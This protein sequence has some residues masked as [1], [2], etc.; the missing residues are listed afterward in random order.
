MKRLFNILPLVAL[1]FGAVA[2][3]SCTN[4]LGDDNMSPNG[5]GSSD[6]IVLNFDAPQSDVVIQTRAQNLDDQNENRVRNL[7]VFIFDADG[8]KVYSYYFDSS[9]KV[10]NVTGR[11]DN[12]WSV[13]NTDNV[14]TKRTQ[15]KIMIRTTSKADA[16][17]SIY[18]ITNLDSSFVDIS[19]DRLSQIQTEEE[20]LRTQGKMLQQTVSRS[21]YLQMSG[22]ME[23]VNIDGDG[24]I[25][26]ATDATL[27][28]YHMD[29]KVQVTLTH[30]SN[31]M[32]LSNARIQIVNLPKVS[33]VWSKY[34]PNDATSTGQ[35]EVTSKEDVF[36]SA[37]MGFDDISQSTTAGV[38]TTTCK[39]WFYMLES[40]QTPK[41]QIPMACPDSEW[42][43]YDPAKTNYNPY[44]ERA[45]QTKDATPLTPG[46]GHNQ[47]DGEGNR[48]FMYANNLSPYMLIRCNIAMEL[49]GEEAGQEL[50]GDVSYLIPLG[51][52]G[53]SAS[54][55]E[56]KVNNYNTNRNTFYHYTVT[57]NGVHNVRVEVDARGTDITDNNFQMEENQPGATGKVVVAKEEIAICDCHY[58]TKT[59][60]FHAKNVSD[61]LTW[62]VSTPFGEGGPQ[63][64]IEGNDVIPPG[65]DYEWAHFRVNKKTSSGAY[66]SDQRRAYTIE[67]YDPVTKPEGLMN[68]SQLV[69][70]MKEQ[71]KLY[72]TEDP[73]RPELWTSD[74]DNGKMVTYNDNGTVKGEED[75]P[76]GRK[77][78]VTVF[79][80]E[81]YYDYNPLNPLEEI[82]ADFWKQYVNYP[83]DRYMYILSESNLSRDE[84]S[85]STGSVVTIQQHP[86]QSIFDT[87]PANTTFKTAWGLE[88]TDEDEGKLNK[89]YTSGSGTDNRGNTDKYNGR[90]N[91]MK[92]WGLVNTTGTTYT[93]KKWSDFMNFEVRN[94][95]PQLQNTYKYLRYS[96]M[97]RN[98]DN[99]G[100]DN[101]DQNEIRWYMAAIK[102]LTGIAV[103]RS[104]LLPESRLYKRSSEDKASN[105]P[106]KWRQH[107]VSSTMLD[108]NSNQP[109]V[110]WGEE[111]T[112]ISDLSGSKQY[113]SST[114]YT[115]NTW[116][117]RCVRN[118]GTK[119]ETLA[120]GYTLSEKPDD[121][122][123]V[124]T[125]GTNHQVTCVRINPQALR[126][127]QNTELVFCDENNEQALLS[128]RF[129]IAGTVNSLPTLPGG[130]N[131]GHAFLNHNQWVEDVGSSGPVASGGTGHCPEGYRIPNMLEFTII[132]N[133]ADDL[134]DQ[135][136]ELGRA[137]IDWT[138]NGYF[139]RNYYSFGMMGEYKKN[140]E[141]GKPGW[142]AGDNT[143]TIQNNI[144][145][146]RCVR[147]ASVD[148]LRAE[149]LL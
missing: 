66:Y 125:D 38:T 96:C 120:S 77:I 1:L 117:V 33:Y 145:K 116:S 121:Y 118:L 112:S 111:I 124:H 127:Q 134:N 126:A 30:G 37:E 32:S 143:I 7:Y 144:S 137:D 135:L 91:T 16:D 14:G 106:N 65:L 62:S 103:G 42:E 49:T 34:A 95:L 24:N 55:V 78:C 87:N 84:E 63:I 40:R 57:V 56:A 86:I 138:E 6:C 27:H 128:K 12:C 31:V 100:D 132:F 148:E 11:N 119:N 139:C 60:T 94:E 54:P 99:N 47:V 25:T 122:I 130:Y 109:T 59:I 52:A 80:D 123:E 5:G 74:F 81:F 36:N 21:G 2:L 45:R 101:I 41:Q 83:T 35:G 17:Y 4:D 149:G 88:I 70:Y 10:D 90:L 9:N 79:V 69:K 115:F 76:D 107:V 64:D 129:Y 43:A 89:A 39:A 29:A 28:L 20:L 110:I 146:V 61:N 50:G 92:E 75:D 58:V 82:P 140:S 67:P 136:G 98:R 26:H 104:V 142:M 15:G 23:N 147:D 114:S 3:G 8:H 71:K 48:N 68:V 108:D 141:A 46:Y 93:A 105:D 102:Q 44:F 72:D 19:S 85:R 22:K 73:A 53:S 131:L 51:D 13:V 18:A 97:T 113:G 133:Y